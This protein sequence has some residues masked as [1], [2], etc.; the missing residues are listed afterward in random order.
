MKK[1]NVVLG[2]LLIVSVISPSLFGDVL[3]E[4]PVNWSG[5]NAY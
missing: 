3:Y 5:T 2:V 1:R 4:Q